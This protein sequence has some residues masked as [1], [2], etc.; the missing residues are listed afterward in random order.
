MRVIQLLGTT[1]EQAAHSSQVIF[2]PQEIN[3]DHVLIG[4]NFEFELRLLNALSS[5]PYLPSRYTLGGR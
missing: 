5:I 3:C 4:P 1:G 2:A